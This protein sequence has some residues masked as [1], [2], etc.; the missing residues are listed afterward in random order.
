MRVVG[1]FSD[2]SGNLRMIVGGTWGDSRDNLG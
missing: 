2:S 1:I